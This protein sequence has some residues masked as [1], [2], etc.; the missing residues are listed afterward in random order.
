MNG[1]ILI[2][3]ASGFL[4]YHLLNI[5]KTL[6]L[7]TFAAVRKESSVSHIEHLA[8]HFVELNYNSVSDLQQVL[9]KHKFEY[10]IHAAAVTR[11]KNAE[12]YT[13]VNVTFA[14]NL[15]LAASRLTSL[16]SFVFV[17]SLAAIGPVS[18]ASP[19]ITEEAP[20]NPVT[21]YGI[22]KK[23]AELALSK[24][25]DLPLK[26]VRPTA[27]Y[28]P[29]EKDLFVL[30]KTLLGGL[31]LHIGKASQKL[32]FIHGED[33]A[34]AI[35]K[36]ALSTQTKSPI[37]FN[38]T[39]GN[40]YDRYALAD[41][42]LKES[43]KKSVRLHL[44]IP[45]IKAAAAGFELAYKWSDNF[46]VLYKER[47]KE[48]TAESWDC[49]ISLIKNQLGFNPRYDLESGLKETLQWYYKENWL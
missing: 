47:I 49:D 40:T 10:I 28:G 24:I 31:D 9:E 4:G 21:G 20:M 34:V 25:P 44:P 22:S 6:R 27:I 14:E 30:F 11:S 29:R 39:D 13:K 23:N 26:I 42:I 18:F 12:V 8:D 48:V 2:T 46:P 5:A 3:G 43:N 32:S 37:S 33:A 1:K 15:A 38:L 41:A 19:K 17:S 36:A 35:I 16:K 45:L 7:E